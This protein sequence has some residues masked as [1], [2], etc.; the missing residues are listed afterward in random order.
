MINSKTAIALT[1]LSELA[2]L[3]SNDS[4]TIKDMSDKA[5]VSSSYTEQTIKSLRDHSFIRSRRGPGGGYV[6]NQPAN[7]ISLS[8]VLELYGDSTKVK[9]GVVDRATDA[10]LFEIQHLKLSDIL[11]PVTQPQAVS[12]A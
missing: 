9:T 1:V 3:E 7:E 11:E 6:L 2:G 10:L 5:G 12:N 4:L 8:K